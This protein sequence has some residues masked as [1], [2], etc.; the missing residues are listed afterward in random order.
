M[1]LFL[2]AGLVL[3]G[4]LT[5]TDDLFYSVSQSSGHLLQKHPL[6]LLGMDVE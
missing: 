3:L 5:I 6:V 2:Y 1:E 4:I